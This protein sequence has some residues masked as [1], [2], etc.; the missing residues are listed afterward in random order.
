MCYQRAAQKLEAALDR[1]LA[2]EHTDPDDARLVKLLRKHRAQLF[3]FLYV[4]GLAPT[5]NAAEREIRPALLVRKTSGGNRSDRGAKTHAVLTS[6]IRTCQKQGRD[7]VA[8]AVELLRQPRP[9]ALRLTGP[10]SV[11]PPAVARGP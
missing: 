5:N 8:T 11:Q 3:T 6:V 10:A 4:E 9:V 2:G 7:F 1:L